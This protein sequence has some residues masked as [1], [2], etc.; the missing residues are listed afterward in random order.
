MNRDAVLAWVESPLQLIGAAEWAA[1]HR[2]TIPVAGRLTPQMSETADLLLARGARFGEM[3]PYLGIPWKLL[4]QHPH[5]LVGDGFSGQFRLAAAILR[6]RTLTFLDD[7]AIALPFADTLLQR[8]PYARPHVTEKGLTSLVAPFAAEAIAR[9]ARSRAAHL[10]T[11]FDL[12]PDRTAALADRGFAI[13]RHRFAWTRATASAP[14]DL[15]ARVILGSARPVD[16]RMTRDAYLRWLAELAAAAPTGA[17]PATYLPHRRETAEQLDAVRR[18]PGV[19]VA[20]ASVPVE[21]IL[22]G[23]TRPLQLHTLP[24]TTSTTLRLVLAG[25][26]STINGEPVPTDQ[27]RAGAER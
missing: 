1:A 10:F 17:E 3:D 14:V 20:E 26:G 25:S 19:A 13:E 2:T 4:A 12:G 15:G 9:R 27:T 6:P 8:R 18:V 16:G 21:L 24:S 7:G 22:A 5:W 23:A 11:A